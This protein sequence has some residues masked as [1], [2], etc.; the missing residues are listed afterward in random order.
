[1]SS[2]QLCWFVCLFCFDAFDFQLFFVVLSVQFGQTI[3]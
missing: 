3:W 2:A 1:M